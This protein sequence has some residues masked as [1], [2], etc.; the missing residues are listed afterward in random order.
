[1]VTADGNPGA[2]RGRVVVV[3][4]DPGVADELKRL[5]GEARPGEGTAA[6]PD[7]LRRREFSWRVDRVETDVHARSHPQA[8]PGD[9]GVARGAGGR[10]G[11][12]PPGPPDPP[13]PPAP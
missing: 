9:P 2:A 12:A 6:M 7:E 11:G 4:T 5:R 13:Q 8:R 3:C 10:G 1:M